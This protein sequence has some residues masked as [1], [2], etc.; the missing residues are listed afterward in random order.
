MSLIIRNMYE[1][2]IL[3]PYSWDFPCVPM[4]KTFPSNTG[5]AG[6][7]SGHETKVSHGQKTKT[8]NR[9]NIVT[10]SIK[11]LKTAYI[12]KVFLNN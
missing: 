5:G 3:N 7:T 9:S 12:K 8:E 6:F 10:N 11:T 4:V 2:H 1:K